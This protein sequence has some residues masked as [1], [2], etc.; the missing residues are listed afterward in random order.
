M[1]LPSA[2]PLCFA[3]VLTQHAH[4]LAMQ[5]SRS[6]GPCRRQCHWAVRRV[7]R[8]A[9]QNGCATEPAARRLLNFGSCTVARDVQGT[10]R[11]SIASMHC[12]AAAAP[13]A[14][15]LQ[16][17]R[18]LR[19]GSMLATRFSGV[20]AAHLAKVLPRR[21][22]NESQGHDIC[23]CWIFS[24]VLAGACPAYTARK[25]AKAADSRGVGLP[26]GLSAELKH[27]LSHKRRPQ[28]ERAHIGTRTAGH[29]HCIS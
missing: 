6:L 8:G 5:T 27:Y 23:S 26:P 22:A 28:L 18:V 12:S 29:P 2:P 10:G 25:D 11:E 17:G 7:L 9:A 3:P 16:P 14:R 19:K 24:D 20:L 1:L 15:L 21:R 4:R 13:L